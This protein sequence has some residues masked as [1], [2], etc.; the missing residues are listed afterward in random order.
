M[1][2]S[3]LEDLSWHHSCVSVWGLGRNETSFWL[4]YGNSISLHPKGYL[5]CYPST[6]FLPLLENRVI[7]FALWKKLWFTCTERKQFPWYDTMLDGGIK[8][9]RTLWISLQT[10]HFHFVSHNRNFPWKLRFVPGTKFYH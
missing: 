1:H 10:C 2:T 6:L 9:S 4:S 3:E 5:A 8:M 7:R